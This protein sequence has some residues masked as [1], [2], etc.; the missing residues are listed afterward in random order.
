MQKYRPYGAN[1]LE[2]TGYY[3]TTKY[4]FVVLQFK[5]ITANFAR[6]LY[7]VTGISINHIEVNKPLSL[8]DVFNHK[9]LSPLMCFF[10]INYRALGHYKLPSV[11]VIAILLLFHLP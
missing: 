4:G 9:E 2:A 10:L 1:F 7:N 3:S 6:L 11:I 5:F 8:A